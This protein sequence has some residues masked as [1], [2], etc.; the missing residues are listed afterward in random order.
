MSNPS[1]LAYRVSES[2]EAPATPAADSA[3]APL[4]LA[5]PLAPRAARLVLLL[6][7]T[8]I[9]LGA[10]LTF[11][12][13][14]MVGKMMLPLLGGAA[15]IWNVCMV[16]FQTTLLAGYG[17]AHL[18]A[19]LSARR[20]LV[21]HLGLLALPLLVL[22]VAAPAAASPPAEGTP[23]FWLLGLLTTV[24]GLPFFVVSTTG[25]L[26]QRWFGRTIHP[27]ASDPYF[28]YA[29][30]N[31]GSLLAL[32]AYPLVIE[33]LLGVENQ[34]RLFSLGYVAFGVL[35]AVCGVLGVRLAGPPA[36]VAAAAPAPA[37]GS[38][39]AQRSR[40]VFLAFIP[41][42]LVLGTTER[43][44]T[45]IAAVPLLW[46][47]PFSLYLVS[48]ILPF[49][50]HRFFERRRPLWVWPTLAILPV[51]FGLNNDAVAIPAQLVVFFGLA[52]LCHLRLA[53][54]RPAPARLTEF[55][56]ALAIG[57]AL[58]GVFNSLLAPL[59]FP[60]L[61]E[62][63][64]ATA[65]GLFAT[66][67]PRRE[68]AVAP[69][70][71]PKRRL[72]LDLVVPMVTLIPVFLLVVYA[73][74][75]PAAGGTGVPLAFAL[76]APVLALVPFVH[77]PLRFGF[78]L[79]LLA[80]LQSSV[81]NGSAI[82]RER[83]FYGR[84]SV[85]ARD[86]LRHLTHGSTRHGSQD[87]RPAHRR[88]PISYYGLG[89]PVRDVIEVAT[90]AARAD[91]VAV[92]G[93]GAGTLAAFAGPGDELT[94]FELDPAVAR[95]ARDPR[96][97][98]F[99]ADSPARVDVRVGDGRL[100]LAKVAPGS[101]GLIVL[102]AFSSDAIP[103]HLLTAEALRVYLDKLAPGGLLALH[104]SNR[105][106]DLRPMLSRLA[107]DA[108]LVARTAR[109]DVSPA[110]EARGDHSS[111]YVVM[112]RRHEDL[113]SLGAMPRW[114]ALPPAPGAVAWTDAWADVL[115]AIR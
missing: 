77:H 3:G 53:R 85:V 106:F 92:L 1:S 84:L 69:G 20:G 105:F 30:S 41:S 47:V 55:Y 74:A 54:A 37:T 60:G 4:A 61:W 109:H 21:L 38:S 101:Y 80:V 36:P 88:Q 100:N 28:L 108:G 94:F 98:T 49:G 114:Q 83:T 115:S 107:A 113:A 32:L 111:V 24:A 82:Y 71:S 43:L 29:A 66:R 8:T 13:Q 31:T 18:N 56:L 58:G 76:T 57:G 81:A 46:V 64:I 78:G 2:G 103:V 79:I 96:Y 35:A 68:A 39:W 16:F 33:R 75:R 73:T 112:G 95:V 27:A 34:A 5:S 45:D 86:G 102:D 97:F 19:K 99:L 7:A 70:R 87:P 48:L 44:S 51:T 40:W 90:H 63:P 22:P 59:L 14:P 9:F 104:V 10:F 6:F 15:T 17:Y 26:V 67:P 89:S 25:P 62:L 12:V 65:L 50:R 110:E 93:L 11:L 91:K 52:L 72:V 23:V 42:S